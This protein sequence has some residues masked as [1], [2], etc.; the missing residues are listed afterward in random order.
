MGEAM[1]RSRN[2]LSIEHTLQYYD[3]AQHRLP[4]QL[5][6]TDADLSRGSR[7]VRRI[8]RR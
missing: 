6:D 3:V 4:Q 1:M 7:I 2:I 8:G 5:R